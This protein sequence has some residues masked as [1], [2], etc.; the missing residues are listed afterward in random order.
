M[1]D[2]YSKTFIYKKNIAKVSAFVILA[3]F[4]FSVGF[5]FGKQNISNDFKQGLDLSSIFA[6]KQ[7]DFSLVENVWNIINKKY[8]NSNTIDKEALIYGAIR[9]MLEE[10]NDPY[11]V[12][13]DKEETGEFLNSVS[14]FFEGIGIEIGIRD[15]FLTV[16]APLKDSPAQKAGIKTQ[17]KI[18]AID[19]EDSTAY[20]LEEAVTKIRGPKGTPVTLTVL[21]GSEKLNITVTR[22]T[23][24]IPSLK[25][26]MLES[27]IAYIELIQ[28]SETSGKDFAKAAS[29]IL[30]SDARRLILDLRNNPGGLL[31]ASINIAGWFLPKDKLVV[32]EEI[33]NDIRR[34]HKSSGPAMLKEFPLVILVNEG[35]ASASEILAGALRDQ[36]NIKIIGKK[37]YGKG[38]VQSLENLAGGTSLKL[39]IARWITPSGHYIN[40]TGIEPDIEIE[41]TQED[42]NNQ[43]DPQKEKAV[44]FIKN[45]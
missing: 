19:G 20:S 16:I 15:E 40:G 39:T 44:E 6:D 25:W 34:E 5:F 2:N 22:D 45:R 42:S 28:F 41:L 36:N 18:V 3:L 17:D 30:E 9:G 8:I 31:D 27:D 38:S 7:V 29:E 33:G 26:E 14:G 37:S 10:L 35:S 21:R 11:T 24:Q 4:I 13:F 1:K 43:R 23:I 12:F 32:T